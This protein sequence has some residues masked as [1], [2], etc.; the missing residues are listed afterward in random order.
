MERRDAGGR[1]EESVEHSNMITCPACPAPAGGQKQLCLLRRLRRTTSNK[2]RRV[3]LS[4]EELNV[5]FT[6]KHTSSNQEHR[7]QACRTQVLVL[8]NI[9]AAQQV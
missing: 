1:R 4:M 2:S 8:G 7:L 9:L 6:N 3:V 5:D